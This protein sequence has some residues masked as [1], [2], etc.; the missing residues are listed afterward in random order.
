MKEKLMINKKIRFK[1]INYFYK[2]FQI[3][4]IYFYYLI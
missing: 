1:L 3:H 2:L 4:F